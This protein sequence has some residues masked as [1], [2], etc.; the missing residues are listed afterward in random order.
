MKMY[1]KIMTIPMWNCLKN[2]IKCQ[3]A[4]IEKYI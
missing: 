3:N 2:T 1:S 4:T